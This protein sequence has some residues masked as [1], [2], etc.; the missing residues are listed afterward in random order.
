MTLHLLDKYTNNPVVSQPTP[1]GVA[2]SQKGDRNKKNMNTTTI[3]SGNT[4]ISTTASIQGTHNPISKKIPRRLLIRIRMKKFEN[5]QVKKIQLVRQ[6]RDRQDQEGN[7]KVFHNP[8][9]YIYMN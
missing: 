4:R 1:E 5:N 8:Q 6:V 9:K 2:F 3:S 7:E